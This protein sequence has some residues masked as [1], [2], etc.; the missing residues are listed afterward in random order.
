MPVLGEDSGVQ[1]VPSLLM[2]GRPKQMSNVVV[3]LASFGGPKKTKNKRR[4]HSSGIGR[5]TRTWQVAARFTVHI[6]NSVRTTPSLAARQSWGLKPMHCGL[7]Q[8]LATA[9]GKSCQFKLLKLRTAPV[10]QGGEQKSVR[11]G[12]SFGRI[13][14]DSLQKLCTL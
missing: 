13:C 3:T 5:A 6:V 14:F 11:S 4:C 1:G 8:I 12:G 10:V 9:F 2:S 7:V